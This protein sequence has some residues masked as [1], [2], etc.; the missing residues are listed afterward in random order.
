[1]CVS[2]RNLAHPYQCWPPKCDAHLDEALPYSVSIVACYELFCIR[3]NELCDLG[4]SFATV[5]QHYPDFSTRDIHSNYVDC[6][7][8][9]GRFVLSK[10]SGRSFLITSLITSFPFPLIRAGIVP[11]STWLVTFDVSS[12]CILAVSSLSNSTARHNK[13]DVLDTVSSTC[14]TGSIRNLVC[15]V[16]CIKYNM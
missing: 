9:F 14:L 3:E 1:M 5:H 6:A 8:W 13:L 7:R 11:N 15:C 16:V 10:V 4:R 2:T 12:P